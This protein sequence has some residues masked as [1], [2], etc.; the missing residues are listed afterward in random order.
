MKYRHLT[1]EMRKELRK[2][3]GQGEV[4]VKEIRHNMDVQYFIDHQDEFILVMEANSLI[5]KA[6]KE[7]GTNTQLV[8]VF[9]VEVVNHDI[10]DSLEWELDYFLS[11]WEKKHKID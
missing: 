8:P 7:Y 2:Q 6:N 4:T 1:E 5:Q 11:Q 3:L 9:N 10:T